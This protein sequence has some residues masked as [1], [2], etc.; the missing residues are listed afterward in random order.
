MLQFVCMAACTV[1]SPLQ[2]P[3]HASSRHMHAPCTLNA[4][5]FCGPEAHPPHC[6]CASPPADGRPHFPAHILPAVGRLTGAVCV[7]QYIRAVHQGSTLQHKCYTWRYSG[8]AVQLP[9]AGCARGHGEMTD[10]LLG[11]HVLL[12]FGGIG[13][14]HSWCSP[15]PT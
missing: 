13:A 1:D 5:Q 8:G 6:T 11:L 10:M 2:R 12:L 15:P 7:G 3:A 14:P 4:D 9:G